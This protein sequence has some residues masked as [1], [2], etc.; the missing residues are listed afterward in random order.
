MTMKSMRLHE[1]SKA[2]LL[3]EANSFGFYQLVEMLQR[4]KAN[5]LLL[6]GPEEAALIVDLLIFMR[7][8]LELQYPFFDEDDDRF[9]PLHEDYVSDFVS[10][11][12]QKTLSSLKADFDVLWPSERGISTT[13]AD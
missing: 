8:R 12:W 3:E 10:G 1:E 2:E 13:K 9:N 5:A 11:L 4:G 7:Q 6:D